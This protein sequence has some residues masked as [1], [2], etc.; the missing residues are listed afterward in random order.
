MTKGA[1]LV[2]KHLAGIKNILDGGRMKIT[3]LELWEVRRFLTDLAKFGDAGLKT[4]IRSVLAVMNRRDLKN[5]G[6]DVV[7]RINAA[8]PLPSKS[9]LTTT[10]GT[11]KRAVQEQ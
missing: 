6:I 1:K 11:M 8:P 10:W 3:Y 7:S 5:F 2:E 4:Y 9:N